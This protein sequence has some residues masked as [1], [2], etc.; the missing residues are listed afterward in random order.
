MS[1]YTDAQFHRSANPAA[2]KLYLGIKKEFLK[3]H[4]LVS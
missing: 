3:E 2:S 4:D 1:F